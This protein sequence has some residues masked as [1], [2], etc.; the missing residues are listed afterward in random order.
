VDDDALAA[1]LVREAGSLAARMLDS[2]LDTHF[3][4][5]ISDVV[6]AADHA[7]EALVAGRL[8]AERHEDGLV[9]EEGARTTEDGGGSGRTW[10]IDPVDGTY[11]F[12]SG[13]PYWCSAVG[14][15]DADGPL[16][17]A[18]Y[19][20]AR[21]ELW[22]GGRDRPTTLNGR[23]LPRLTDRPLAEVSVATYSNASH[24][25]DRVKAASWNAATTSAATTRMFGSASVDLAGV[26]TGRIGVFLQANLHPWDWFP[27]AALVL[28]AGGVA[29]EVV[30]GAQ[31]WLVAGNR[32]AVT[33]TRVAL[34]E[35]AAALA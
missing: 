29:E 9:G 23:E 14:L 16:L 18:V 8:A 32:Q 33:D 5:S 12:L 3:K 24:L 35:A 26:A 20:P 34:T 13:I 22:V 27:G 21:D 31:R 2:G 6:S 28:G 4:T 25:R 15:T 19:Y 7:A 30:I 10:Y 1:D 17:G 11:N